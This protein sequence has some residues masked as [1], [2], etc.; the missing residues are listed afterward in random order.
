LRIE[1]ENDK[2][3]KINGRNREFLKILGEMLR[4]GGEK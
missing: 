1:G 2:I 3:Y 4:K